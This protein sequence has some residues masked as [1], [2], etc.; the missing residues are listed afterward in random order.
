MASKADQINELISRSI[1]EILPSPR[2]LARALK[3]GEKLT[4]YL[5]VDPTAPELHLGH[6]IS[7][8]TLKRF[9]KL[10]HKVVLLVGDFTARIGD[11]SGKTKARKPL[12]EKEV[13]GNSQTYKAQA[14]KILDFDSPHNPAILAFNSFWHKKLSFRDVLDLASHFSVQQMLVR[15][16]FDKRVKEG[17]P[18]GLNELLY[19][20]MQGYDSVAL[21]TDVEVGGRDQLFNMLVGRD[22]VKRYLQKEKFVVAMR[23]LV[24]PITGAKM[25]KSEG[26]YIA[27]DD[28]PPNMYGKV[29]ALPDEVIFD[30][31]QLCTEVPLAEIEKI[32]KLPARDAKAYLA[33][34]IVSMYHGENHA[35]IAENKFVAVFREH[36][37]PE[38]LKVV[39]LSERKIN[40][41]ELLYSTG[42]V[43]SKSE[44]R[45]LLAQ[46]GVRVKGEGSSEWRTV[47]D[48][49]KDVSIESPVIIRAG[50]RRFVEARWRSE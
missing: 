19:P 30:C 5:G 45:R 22:L 17:S 2:A 49:K 16:M 40:I 8:L 11:P 20:L 48:S 24:N 3:G 28:P 25:S 27:L 1:A 4:V 15:D 26:N 23:L 21:R 39:Y 36:E 13:L 42:L 34:E 18:I 41:V 31:F 43:P 46:Q 6:S 7:L 38:D 10:G 9:Q 50:K 33:R 32:R 29:M 47:E 35:K 14:S 44:A 37:L 12:S